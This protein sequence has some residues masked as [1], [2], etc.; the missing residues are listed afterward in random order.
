MSAARCTEEQR[1]SSKGTIVS[2]SNS[3]VPVM[4]TEIAFW[5]SSPELL[6]P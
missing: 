3:G 6:L 1:A 5:L 2:Q 4:L